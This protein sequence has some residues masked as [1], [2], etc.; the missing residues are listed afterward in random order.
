LLGWLRW[1]ECST[2][3]NYFTPTYV[4]GRI[5]DIDG[6]SSYELLLAFWVV[7]WG[8]LIKRRGVGGII[9]VQLDAGCTF[10]TRAVVL[11]TVGLLLTRLNLDSALL[12]LSR[13]LAA[14]KVPISWGAVDLICLISLF[15]LLPWLPNSQ[16]TGCTESKLPVLE[17]VWRGNGVGRS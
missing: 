3:A 2:L 10:G 9:M 4:S 5:Y 1:V 8:L 17:I 14:E 6:E 12:E 7:F 11:L 16:V 13:R 15:G